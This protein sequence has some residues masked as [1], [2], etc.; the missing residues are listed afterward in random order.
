MRVGGHH[1]AGAGAVARHAR[2][3]LPR[4]GSGS[5]PAR[6]ALRGDDGVRGAPT[7]ALLR[8]RR[9]HGP[10]RR[11]ARR[12]RAVDRRSR[13][14]HARAGDPGRAELDR[15]VRRSDGQRLRLVPAPCAKT[16]LENQCWKDSWDSISYRDGRLPGFP[17]ATCELQGYA[18]DAKV[19]GARLAREVWR[20]RRSPK[21]SSRAADLKRR[22]NDL[23]GRI[24]SV[25]R[26]RAGC[27]RQPGRRAELEQRPPPLERHRRDVEGEGGRAPP[28][29]TTTVHRLGHPHAGRGRRALQSGRL[30]RRHDLAVR[31]L[32]HRLGA[33][34]LRLQAGGGADRRWHPQRRRLLRRSS[35]E[36]FGATSGR[37]QPIRGVSNRWPPGLVDERPLLLL[38]TML[39]LEPLGDH[40]IV[41]PALPSGIGVLAL[42]EI[43]GRWGRVDAFARGDRPHKEV[44]SATAARAAQGGPAPGANASQGSFR[45][46]R[47]ADIARGRSLWARKDAATLGIDGPRFGVARVQS[48]PRPIAPRPADLARRRGGRPLPRMAGPAGTVGPGP[49]CRRSRSDGSSGWSCSRPAASLASGSYSRSP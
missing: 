12:V 20:I 16:G 29:G 44:G 9:C 49:F 17:R 14:V 35:A 19:R 34:T 41:D 21:R 18:Y 8:L 6:V 5:H 36:A 13:L 47:G 48:G 25:L 15:R 28:D 37:R 46:T 38:R 26:A 27:G 40:L 7:L 42:L 3:R 4:R 30:P 32:V 39:G 43:P 22:F 11:V 33:A 10:V 24:R 2:R 1:S 45:S 23:L 31:Q